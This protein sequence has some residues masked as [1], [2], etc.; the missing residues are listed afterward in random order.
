MTNI[1]QSN[2]S[3]PTTI[4]Q[5]AHDNSMDSILNAIA[6][7]LPPIVTRAKLH[8]IV[9]IPPKTSANRDSLGTGVK[10]R[11]RVHGKIGYPRDA[12]IVWLRDNMQVL[13]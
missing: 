6:Q 13:S 7:A 1:T 8:E 11:V 4:H 3:N 12:V 5:P 9:G 10:P 2:T